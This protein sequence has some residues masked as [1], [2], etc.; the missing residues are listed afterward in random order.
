MYGYKTRINWLSLKF[1]L[2]TN[3][4]IQD[5]KKLENKDKSIIKS[6]LVWI[7][8][9]LNVIVLGLTIYSIIDFYN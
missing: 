8:I 5:T 3:A 4:F 6:I 1:K 2:M 7:N 9:F